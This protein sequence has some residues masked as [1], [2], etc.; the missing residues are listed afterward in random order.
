MRERELF[1]TVEDKGAKIFR[2]IFYSSG[3]EKF[4]QFF[5]NFSSDTIVE[6]NR[7][8][9]RKELAMDGVDFP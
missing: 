2:S 4:F 3:I 7:E 8:K 6:I 9:G 5:P 1:Q